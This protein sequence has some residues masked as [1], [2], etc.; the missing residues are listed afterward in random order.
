MVP[1]S[2]TGCSLIIPRIPFSFKKI[3]ARQPGPGFTCAVRDVSE[4][5]IGLGCTG[6]YA[7]GEDGPG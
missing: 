1:D 7:H 5:G 3:S 4:T 2:I 6:V